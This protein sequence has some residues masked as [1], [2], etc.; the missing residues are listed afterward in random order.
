MVMSASRPSQGRHICATLMWS[1]TNFS[2]FAFDLLALFNGT[3]R[4]GF[5]SSMHGFEITHQRSSP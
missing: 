2:K 3:Y 1:D 5:V 4:S